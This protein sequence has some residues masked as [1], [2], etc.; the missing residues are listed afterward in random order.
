MGIC[1]VYQS[2]GVDSV[3]RMCK[4]W[5]QK[6]LYSLHLQQGKSA[7]HIFMSVFMTDVEHE[8]VRVWGSPPRVHTAADP[9]FDLEYADDVLLLTRTS[10]QIQ[11]L[12]HIIEAQAV[13][14]AMQLNHD[15]V[16][17]I[18]M[19]VPPSSSVRFLS[20]ELVERVNC[21][22]YLGVRV[23][24]DG[25]QI[26]NLSVRLAQASLEFN[27]LASFWSHAS[28]S[29]S[30]KLRIYKAIFY[31][32]ILYA[33]HYSWLTKSMSSKLDQWQARTLRR[34][35]RIKASMI[36]RI[37]NEEVRK[38]AKCTPLSTVVRQNRFKYFGHVLRCT[39]QD[40]IA[41][42]CFDST[43][44]IRQRAGRRQKRRP[45]DC[46]PAKVCEEVLITASRTASLVRPHPSLHPRTS[47]I[48]Y[49]RSIAK[50]RTTWRQHF[51]RQAHAPTGRWSLPCARRRR[52]PVG[53]GNAA[54]GA[55]R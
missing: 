34:V 10:D 46:W 33:L 24:G 4:M 40:T 37:S 29:T 8:Y 14:Y 26:A 11:R 20:G 6:S 25:K 41:N 23:S 16:K 32:M 53:R 15:K 1:L 45:L 55:G 3:Q 50:Y 5:L 51:S 12:L 9:L 18:T 36:S 28:I 21:W 43:W 19:N 17:L 49:A 54:R 48:L 44:K 13:K 47:G 2:R 42:V 31:P 30:L 27:K 7:L 22:P 52:A 35:L 39:P 38:R